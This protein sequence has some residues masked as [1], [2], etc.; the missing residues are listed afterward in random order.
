MVKKH[1]SDV[2]DELTR[3]RCEFDDG[4]AITN[5]KTY[6]WYV[7]NELLHIRDNSSSSVDIGKLG[8][9]VIYSGYLDNG[10]FYIRTRNEV[11]NGDVVTI[12]ELVKK[13]GDDEST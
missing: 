13:H 11:Q 6:D 7:A 2:I 12:C 3:E 10:T 9:G 1:Q 4:I 5:D 8:D